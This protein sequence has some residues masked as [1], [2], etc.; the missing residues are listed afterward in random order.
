VHALF[1][2][3]SRAHS[4]ERAEVATKV[5]IVKVRRFKRTISRRSPSPNFAGLVLPQ[6]SPASS[7]SGDLPP[8][9][10]IGYQWRK[11]QRGG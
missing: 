5:V 3:D 6:I 10:G 11:A 7:E 4:G 1:K 2:V 9:R 8:H